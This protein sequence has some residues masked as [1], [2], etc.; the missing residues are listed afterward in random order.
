MHL[1]PCRGRMAVIAMAAAIAAPGLY[2]QSSDLNTDPNKLAAETLG[3]QPGSVTV[4]VAR[5]AGEAFGAAGETGA[6]A[7]KPVLYEIGS[8]SKVFTG[9]LLAQ[10]V[11]KGEL[12]LDDNLGKLLAGQVTMRPEVAAITLRQLVTHSSCLPR[13]PDGQWDDEVRDPYRDFDRA[14]L[15]DALA[16]TKLKQSPPCTDEYSNYGFA[17]LGETLS[18]RYKKP[19]ETMVIEGIAKPLGMQDTLQHLG[20]RQA[21][22]AKPWRGA[23]EWSPWHS[24]AFAATGALRSTAPDMLKFS[25][26]MLAGRKGPFG[27]AAERALQPLGRLADMEI[28]YAV[29]IRGPAERRT[30]SHGGATGGYRAHWMILPDT[31]EALIVLASNSGTNVEKVSNAVIAERYKLAKPTTPAVA[32]ANPAEYNGVYRISPKLAM[33]FVAQNGTV[34]GRMTGQLFIP[35]TPT[36][37]D[38]FVHERAGAEFSFQREGGK[39]SG[40]TLRQR[41]STMEGKRSEEAVPAQAIMDGVTQEAFG[42][43]YRMI[44][45]GTPA[46]F[47][48]RVRDGQLLIKL[49]QQPMIGVLPVAGKPDRFAYDVVEAEVQFERNEDKKIIA[50]LHYQNG[51]VLRAERQAA[52]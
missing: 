39:V 3:K 9:L 31:S 51:Q 14:M 49:E 33:T 29:M 22:F 11:E 41:G 36:A 38:T 18:V 10:A 12:S 16:K 34:Y 20:D 43:R 32:L 44:E 21:R 13:L 2:A 28:G 15:W 37:A 48:V 24:Q 42:G 52:Q 6:E 25:R 45:N 23:R 8:I 7:G 1:T 26:A 17:V 46:E 30:Y 5:G 35:M 50:L 27:G 4:G 47:E 19:W 40:V